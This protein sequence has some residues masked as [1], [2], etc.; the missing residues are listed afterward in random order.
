M[1][2][3]YADSS[4]LVKRHLQEIGT[5]WVQALTDPRTGNTVVTTQVSEVEGISAIQRRMREGFIDAGVA[6]QLGADFRAL[7]Q[8]EYRLVTV[9]PAVV[10]RACDLL[11]QHALRAYDALQLASALITNDALQAAGLNGATFLSADRQLLQA[12]R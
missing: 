10:T 1:A 3:Y 12:A 7:C 4:V 6:G 5:A 2:P 9:T 8:R 11:T